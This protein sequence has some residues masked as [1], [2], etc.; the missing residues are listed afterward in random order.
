MSGEEKNPLEKAADLAIQKTEELAEAKKEQDKSKETPP[1]KKSKESDEGKSTLEKA[2]EDQKDLQKILS[3]KDSEL[4]EEDLAKKKEALSKDKDTRVQEKVDKRIGELVTQLDDLKADKD[5]DK[6]RIEALEKELNDAKKKQ[7]G[8]EDV[9]SFAD[10]AAK[11]EKERVEKYLEE[12]KDKSR[13]VKREMSKEDL[14]EWLDEDQVEAHEWMT[15]RTIRKERERIA[16]KNNHEIQT[17]TENF[18]EKQAASS[19]KVWAK[20]PELNVAD[21]TEE[22]RSELE[23]KAKGEGKDVKTESVATAINKEIF[24]T[25]CKENPKY[26]L[27]SE[28]IQED[29]KNSPDGKSSKYLLAEDGA[30]L[31]MVEMEKRLTKEP[32]KEEEEEGSDEKLSFEN[33]EELDAYIKEQ[34]EEEEERIKNI[35]E[36]ISSTRKGDKSKKTPLQ[37]KQEKLAEM[38]GLTKE[39]L[40]NNIKRR[41]RIPGAFSGAAKDLN[42]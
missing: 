25:L 14:E 30:E 17:A 40:D 38:A 36:D 10:K 34:K 22:I 32:K 16:F 2:E 7:K 5:A 27:C 8:E 1:E 13:E 6:G 28:I 9:E 24:E 31:V 35:D 42:G 3:T 33:K 11:A 29:V 20:H 12:D 4:S 41:N 19:S 39:Q 18:Y 26:K 37:E 21:R 15:R 23:T